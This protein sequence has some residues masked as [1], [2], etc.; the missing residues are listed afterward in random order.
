MDVETVQGNAADP[1]VLAAA[2]LPATRRL[3][4]TVPERLEA[5]QAVQQ[6][7]AENPELKNHARAHSE[8]SVSHL[9]RLGANRVIMA[10]WKAT[11]RMLDD[12]AE[13]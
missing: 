5:G 3:F 2:N 12:T 9:Q 10:E 11:H 6:A 8:A 13:A 1:E 7:R 4:V